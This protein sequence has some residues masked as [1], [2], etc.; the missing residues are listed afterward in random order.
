[1]GLQN[2]GSAQSIST[3][4]KYLYNQGTTLD[5]NN[6]EM[7]E[8]AKIELSINNISS[9]SCKVKL[10]LYADSQRT[11]T[12]Q[13]GGE[14]EMANCNSSMNS[15]TFE[16]FFILNYYFEKDQPL[17]FFISGSINGK[18]S[19][20]LPSI[21]GSRGMLQEREI[22][23]GNGAKLV[24]KGFAYK[25]KQTASLIFNVSLNGKFSERGICYSIKALGNATKPQNTVLYK[26]EVKNA[27]MNNSGT[28]TYGKSSIPD[29]Y[30][31]PDIDYN[32]NNVEVAINDPY[33]NKVLGQYSGPLGKLLTSTGETIHLPAGKNAVVSV[34]A[35]KNYQFLDY[36]RGGMQMNLVVAVDFTGSNGN[37]KNPNSLHYLGN[38]ANAYEIAIRSCGSIVAYYD[39]DQLFPAFGFGGR[40]CGDQKAHH[41]Y[42]LNM[43][44]DNPEIAGVDGILQC[45][46][47]I[48]NQT[49]LFG[50]TLFH[51]VIN[52]VISVVKEDVIAENKMNYTI[53]MILTDGIIDDM[54]ETIDALVE[55]SFL[56][57]SVIIIGI[58]DADFTNMN[59]L[60]ADDEPLRDRTGRKTDRDLVQFVPFKKY[61]YNGEQLAQAV[62]EEV[63]KQVIEYY[64]HKKIPPKEPIFNIP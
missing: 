58:G 24:M 14:T 1:M 43:N 5:L 44:F 27:K 39:Y 60:D 61:S 53:L 36:I 49:Q 63:P 13:G 46:R 25:Q 35:M 33:H 17:D 26:S 21:I 30:I 19:T 59:V 52:K 38:N 51:E 12:L 11:V 34:E 22:E 3:E 45:Y 57:I 20:T 7:K 23:G 18:V 32:S 9:G 40:F 47:T 50:P 4:A 15:I 54:E 62:L 6:N 41:C 29:I 64:Q 56:P 31:A 8:A 16:K 48:L 10:V 37:P 28:I 55:A 42:P 2:C